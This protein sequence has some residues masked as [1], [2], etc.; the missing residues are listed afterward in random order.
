MRKNLD[1]WHERHLYRVI[2]SHDEKYEHRP[3]RMISNIVWFSGKAGLN[4]LLITHELHSVSKQTHQEFIGFPCDLELRSSDPGKVR[5]YTLPQ[6]I[7][8]FLWCISFETE[9][10]EG[11]LNDIIVCVI[12]GL[13]ICNHQ[14]FIN[15]LYYDQMTT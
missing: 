13:V 14:T 7:C 15:W 10:S 8:N 11:N 4:H 5:I 3:I 12:T 1:N 2:S 6:N 9:C